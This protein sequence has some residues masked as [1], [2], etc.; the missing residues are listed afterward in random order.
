MVVVGR[1]RRVGF[2]R[3]KGKLLG[4][5]IIARS[6]HCR[7]D[8]HAVEGDTHRA[9]GVFLAT[10]VHPVVDERPGDGDSLGDRVV[11]HGHGEVGHADGVRVPTVGAATVIDPGDAGPVLSTLERSD[12]KLENILITHNHYDHTAGC[13]DLKAA[14]GCNVIGPANAGLSILDQ[15][16][17]DGDQ[18]AIGS[19]TIK[20]MSTPGHTAGHVSFY[21]ADQEALWCGDTLFVAGCGRIMGSSARTL[22]S[23]ITK[24]SA[25]PDETKIYCGHEYTVANLKFAL[26]LEPDNAAVANRLREV[27]EKLSRGEPSV[28]TTVGIEKQ[29][30]PFL[31]AGSLG[32]TVGL[33]DSDEADIFAEIRK[34]KDRW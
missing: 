8:D 14:T 25:L 6:G 18:L 7:E 13:D 28:P 26:S 9:S 20:V 23:S 21:S 16:I 27:E 32:E 12:T 3:I 31:R 30:N 29:T 5:E 19:V 10:R 17:E 11:E 4:R 2:V 33:A 24:I 34:R 1:H 15:A 22:W